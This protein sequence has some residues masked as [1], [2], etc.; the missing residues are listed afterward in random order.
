MKNI[1]KLLEVR[2]KHLQLE[3][4]TKL[5]QNKDVKSMSGRIKE[6]SWLIKKLKTDEVENAIKYLESKIKHIKKMKAFSRKTLMKTKED[7]I[8]KTSI[9]DFIV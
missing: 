1:L 6:N 5:Y 7:V 8:I 2:N 9:G 3:Y 4:A